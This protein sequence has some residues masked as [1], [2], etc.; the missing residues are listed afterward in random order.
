M[1]GWG[2]WQSILLLRS[3]VHPLPL[4]LLAVAALVRV[5][6]AA[7]WDLGRGLEQHLAVRPVVLVARYVMP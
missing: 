3:L 1:A 4:A 6:G 7:A 2:C 5:V